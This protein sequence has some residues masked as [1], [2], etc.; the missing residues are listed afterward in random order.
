MI[1]HSL[2]GFTF[3]QNTSFDDTALFQN[4]GVDDDESDHGNVGFPSAD[5]PMDFEGAPPVE[6]FFAEDQGGGD[7]L[8][9]GGMDD[10]G[11]PPFDDGEN[12]SVGAV[13]AEHGTGGGPATF[14]PFDP[15]RAPNQKDLVMAMTDGDGGMLDY[16]DQ[17]FLKNWAGP[18]HWKLRRAVKKRTS[19]L[20]RTTLCTR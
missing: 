1:S 14:V 4:I 16:F 8:G 10:F 12:G 2:A 15:R 20:S 18:Q 5:D 6:D 17:T 9:G 19:S 3:L 13:A 7:V 11:T